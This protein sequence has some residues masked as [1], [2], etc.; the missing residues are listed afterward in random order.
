MGRVQLDPQEVTWTPEDGR[1]PVVFEVG[2]ISI[3][4]ALLLRALLERRGPPAAGGVVDAGVVEGTVDLACR[5]VVGWRNVCLRGDEDAP[6]TEMSKRRLLS[7]YR[8]IGAVNAILQ[9]ALPQS[10]TEERKKNSGPGSGS[11]SPSH[12][13]CA[14]SGEAPSENPSAAAG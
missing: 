10:P 11:A 8:N 5:Y 9:A 1:D 14:E 4:D 6:C 2:E 3:A 13:S 7:S 12:G